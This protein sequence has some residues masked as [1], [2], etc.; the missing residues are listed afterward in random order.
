MLPLL[1][2][3]LLSFIPL[4]LFVTF[5]VSAMVALV[6]GDPAVAMAGQGATAEQI[7]AIRDRLGLDESMLDQYRTWLAGATRGDLGESLLRTQDVT[8]LIAR[9]LPATLSLTLLTLL[10][11]VVVAVPAGILAALRPGGWFDRLATVGASV[12]VAVPSFWIGIVLVVV[13]AVGL[14]W[15]PATGYVALTEDPIEWA[16]HLILPAIALGA[17][18]IAEATRQLRAA[19]V[20]V[21]DMDYIRTA[22]AMGLP[23]RAVV[24]KHALK[25]SAAPLVT[26]LG[27]QV[28]LLLGGALIVETVFAIPGM[29]QLAIRAVLDR[30]LPVI[31]GI[32]VVSTLVVLA[33]NLIVDLL[34]GYLNPKVRAA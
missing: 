9:R 15:L 11:T 10:L 34:Y 4:V 18:T 6:P 27:L 13:F 12:G 30:D 5:A 20:D 28:S 17:A 29:G 25:N 23:A 16:K 2:R 22:T 7:A 26:V 19:L 14:G 21:L 1:A 24:Y 33:A 32:V 8:T 3:R 31:Q